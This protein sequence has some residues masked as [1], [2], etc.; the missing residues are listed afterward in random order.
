MLCS[1]FVK[2]G[3]VPRPNVRL[4]VG[5]SSHTMGVALLLVTAS[6]LTA[7]LRRRQKALDEDA[8]LKIIERRKMAALKKRIEGSVPQKADAE[9]TDREL[10]EGLLY[11]RGEEVLEAAYSFFP[12]ETERVVAELAK[13]IRDGSLVRRIS[14]GELYSLFRQVG[15]RFQLKTSIKVQ[16][17]GKFVDLSEKL[18]IREDE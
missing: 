5:L 11:D 18:K 13:R 10:F 9:K 1:R 17:R 6:V 7:V 15:L 2:A 12:Q 14:G 8:E 3:R 4:R 16:E